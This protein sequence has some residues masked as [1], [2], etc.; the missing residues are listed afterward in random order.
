MFNRLK[1]AFYNALGEPEPTWPE[2]REAENI[3]A[4][5]TL[6]PKFPYSRPTFLQ[7]HSDEEIAFSSDHQMRPIIVPKDI[8]KLPW[9]S[10]YAEAVN[11]GKS[12]LNEDQACVHR[13][14]LH[15]PE[16]RSSRSLESHNAAAYLPYVYFGIFDGHA[17]IGAAVA[18]SNQLHHIIQE[19]LVDVL[20]HLLPPLEGCTSA[21]VERVARRGIALWFP[22]KEISIESLIVGALESAFWDMDQLIAEDRKKYKIK[23]GCTAL[24]ALFIL[25]KLYVANAGDSRAVVCKNNQALPMSNDFTPESERQRV[26]QLAALRPSLLG[27]DFT[28]LDFN[29]RPVQRDL[30]KRILYR[31]AYMTGW[32]YKT[33][34]AQDLKIPVVNGEGKRSRV[35]ATIGVTR[36]FGDHDLRALN[37]TPVKPFLSSQPEVQI[38]DI[39]NENIDDSDLLIMGTDGLWDVTSNER[40][41]ETVKKSLSHFSSDN[42]TRK[43]RYTSA[44]QDLVMQSRGK[45]IEKNIWRTSDGRSA[46]IDDISVFVIPLTPYKKEFLKWQSEFDAIHGLY[47]N[48]LET[49]NTFGE[50]SLKASPGKISMVKTLL[51]ENLPEKLEKKIY[52]KTTNVSPLVAEETKPINVMTNNVNVNSSAEKLFHYASASSKISSKALQEKNALVPS[53]SEESKQMYVQLKTETRDVDN[54]QRELRRDF[55]AMDMASDSFQ[56]KNMLLSNE[57]SMQNNL[58]DEPSI[59]GENQ[60]TTDTKKHH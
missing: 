51:K 43:Y 41:V 36:G 38:L 49:E 30:G 6:N 48:N 15:R 11:A 60:T 13:E 58:L 21:T 2:L 31:D 53:A 5:K 33:V 16:L 17:G 50:L 34:S 18:A 46:T 42:D 32:A 12:E 3:P 40:A 57:I 29:R 23:G 47:D 20:D 4:A 24:V 52:T 10:G 37:S 27:G 25:G 8:S 54:L 56:S 55:S 19:K 45:L 35:L 39:M 22:E 26:R 7:F 28:H 14:V 1:S 9:D 44:A 59:I